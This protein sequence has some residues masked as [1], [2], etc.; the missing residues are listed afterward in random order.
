MTTILENRE[1]RTLDGGVIP[2]KIQKATARYFLVL[3]QEG[4]ERKA[5]KGIFTEKEP[6]LRRYNRREGN[7]LTPD[8]VVG[9]FNAYAWNASYDAQKWFLNEKNTAT[10]IVEDFAKEPFAS[11]D[12]SG[13]PMMWEKKIIFNQMDD[14]V[15]SIKRSFD[16]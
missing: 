4:Y 3:E 2:I 12:T 11:T 14:I 16:N 6:K 8:E 7:V 15:V 13:K 1:I 5:H 10:K 9:A